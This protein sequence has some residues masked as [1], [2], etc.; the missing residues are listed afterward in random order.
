MRVTVTCAVCCASATAVV[1][2]WPV[3]NMLCLQNQPAEE[4]PFE[5]VSLL[6]VLLIVMH[7]CTHNQPA[8]TCLTLTSC[9][10]LYVCS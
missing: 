3:Q 1:C 4:G 10:P 8:T 9:P 6:R 2:S 7:Q 5:A